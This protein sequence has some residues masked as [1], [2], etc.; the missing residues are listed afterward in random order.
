MRTP[1]NLFPHPLTVTPL[2]DNTNLTL[3]AGPKAQ[4]YQP[5]TPGHS[6]CLLEM[7]SEAG[8]GNNKAVGSIGVVATSGIGITVCG[9]TA[10]S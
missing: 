3:W 10:T 5:A 1:N 9:G 6:P 4:Y 7:R 2:P 8:K